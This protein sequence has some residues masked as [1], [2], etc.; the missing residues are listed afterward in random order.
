MNI[1]LKAKIPKCLVED[2]TL[3]VQNVIYTPICNCYVFPIEQL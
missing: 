3:N 1:N 2:L